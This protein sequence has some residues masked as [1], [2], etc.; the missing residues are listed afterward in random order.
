[1]LEPVSTGH[2]LSEADLRH[3]PT[4][5]PASFSAADWPRVVE[6]RHSLDPDGVFHGFP[7]VDA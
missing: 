7:G 6:L 1:V 2:F 3:T 4:R 5:V